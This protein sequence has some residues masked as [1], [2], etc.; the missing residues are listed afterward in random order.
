MI[1]L[2]RETRLDPAA[3]EFLVDFRMRVCLVSRTLSTYRSIW[4]LVLHSIS[5]VWLHVNEKQHYTVFFHVIQGLTYSSKHFKP[6]LR[7]ACTELNWHVGHVS[8]ETWDTANTKTNAF[9]LKSCTNKVHHTLKH[10]LTHKTYLSV[11]VGVCAVAATNSKHMAC[12][13][14]GVSSHHTQITPTDNSRRN[15]KGKTLEV[16]M[17]L[18]SWT[19]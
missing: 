6:M 7:R 13:Y 2:P 14:R 8:V 19:L 15:C 12:K 4:L 10:A 3:V 9:S 11:F 16:M 5:L 18:W 17:F 1:L